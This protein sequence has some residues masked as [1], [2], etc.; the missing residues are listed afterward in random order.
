VVQGNLDRYL[1]VWNAFDTT[2]GLATD[3]SSMLLGPGGQKLQGRNLTTS[4]E[5]HQVDVAYNTGNDDYLVVFVRAYS[6]Q[7]TGNDIYGLRVNK[8]NAVVSPPGVFEIHRGEGNQNAPRVATNSSDVF[9]VVWEHEHTAADRDIYGQLIKWD[10]S[11]IGP[12]RPLSTSTQDETKPV[13]AGDYLPHPLEPNY[14]FLVVW[15]QEQPGPAAIIGRTWPSHSGPFYEFASYPFWET[16]APAV[17]WG[18]PS[19]LVAYEGDSVG[20]P[21][22]H[23]HI[24][25]R[26]WSPFGAFLPAAL[27]DAK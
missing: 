11:K 14:R 18:R 6:A 7:S 22:V 15:Q 1:V 16:A 10:G 19:V 9:F 21:T 20:D 27:R 4:T 13:V 3:I 24:Y 5:P 12:L 17:A 25:G 8:D 2:T 26:R 23:R